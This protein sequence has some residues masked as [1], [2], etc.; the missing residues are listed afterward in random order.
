M[1]DASTVTSDAVHCLQMSLDG[2]ILPLLRLLLEHVASDTPPGP[3]NR[4][5]MVDSLC[6]A[7]PVCKILLSGG[8]NMH[9]TCGLHM[10]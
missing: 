5:H 9:K 6:G 8:G 3:S 2:S 4:M 1:T 10:A 7:A